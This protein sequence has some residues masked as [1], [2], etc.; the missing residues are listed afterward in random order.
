MCVLGGLVLFAFVVEIACFLYEVK[1]D[2]EKLDMKKLPIDYKLVF[3]DEDYQRWEFEPQKDI[4]TYETALLLPVFF[5]TPLPMNRF[6]YIRKHNLQKHFKKV[7]NE[8]Q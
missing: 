7:E 6:I 3:I 5:Y 2:R 8:A 1:S 4:T